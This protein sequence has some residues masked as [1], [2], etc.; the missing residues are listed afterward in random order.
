MAST[1]ASSALRSRIEPWEIPADTVCLVF[2]CA[3]LNEERKGFGHLKQALA[4]AM[5]TPA[6]AR[7]RVQL[8]L[9]GA[10]SPTLDDL[11][12][13]AR[14]LGIIQTEADMASLYHAADASLCP[15]LEDNLPNTVLES[16]ACGC[17]V[18]GFCTGGLPDMVHHGQTGLLAPCGDSA[19]L[20][21]H[22]VDFVTSPDLRA[23]LHRHTRTQDPHRF[24]LPTQAQTVKALYESLTSPHIPSLPALPANNGFLDGSWNLAAI[25]EA[26]QL[27][28]ER[29]AK[30]RDRIAKAKQNKEPPP[31]KPKSPWWK[32]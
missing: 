25:H 23:S 9:F 14:H 13:P 11:P 17:P 20:A 1:P 24:A 29:E 22:L 12:L 21:Q 6:F 18:I 19:E 3:S 26:L 4:T 5:Q 2:G 15:T 32:R 16:L 27:S 8:L 10:E 28:I 31:T 30:L 7:A